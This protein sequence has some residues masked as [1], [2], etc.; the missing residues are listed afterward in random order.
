[1]LRKAIIFQLLAT[2]KKDF[3][4]EPKEHSIFTDTISNISNYISGLF[5]NSSK[6]DEQEKSDQRNKQD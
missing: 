1:M 3:K 5:T 6:E 4:P 2:P